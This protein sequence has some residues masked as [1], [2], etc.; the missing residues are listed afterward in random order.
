MPYYPVVMRGHT[1][2]AG[3]KA[4]T[5]NEMSPWRIKPNDSAALQDAN[6]GLVAAKLL[7][8]KPAQLIVSGL[9]NGG[10]GLGNYDCCA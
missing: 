5:S 4:E 10:Y 6:G 3:A 2:I 9:L 7:A 1:R 8:C